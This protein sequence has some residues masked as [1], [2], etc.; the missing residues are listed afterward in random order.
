MSFSPIIAKN[1]MKREVSIVLSRERKNYRKLAQEW[2][3][4]TDEQ[5]KGMDVHHNPPRS[6]GGRNIPEHLFVYHETLHSAVHGDE[7]TRFAREGGKLGGQ[8]CVEE[9]I[10]FLGATREQRR[11]WGR[12]GNQRLLE[13]GT[14]IHAPGVRE[15]SGRKA[16]EERLGMFQNHSQSIARA[17]E[18][19]RQNKTGLYNPETARK[20]N[21]TLF[22]D[23]DHPELGQHN[24]GN[25][26]HKQKAKGLPHGKENRRRV[27]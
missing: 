3:D 6:Q 1:P 21:L 10:G 24:A 26:V 22:E 12:Q 2:F 7:L 4:L 14:G 17:H 9:K 25:L 11:E 16:V 8:K 23:P 20:G 27:Q 15:A 13:L 18:V 19:Q 5:M